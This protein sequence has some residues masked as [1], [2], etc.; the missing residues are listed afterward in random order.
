M[1]LVWIH[2]RGKRLVLVGTAFVAAIGMIA[3]SGESRAAAQPTT[4][5]DIALYQ[6]G[7]RQQILVEGAQKKA[8]LSF[9]IPTPGWRP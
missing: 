7:D 5:A 9:T 4:V 6:G 2:N 3:A 1:S 8:S